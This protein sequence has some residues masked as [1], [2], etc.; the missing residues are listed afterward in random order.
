MTKLTITFAAASLLAV[1]S[2]ATV[3]AEQ[4]VTTPALGSAGQSGTMG[5]GMMNRD[6]TAG[7]DQTS[8]NAPDMMAMMGRMS[9]MMDACDA[10]MK[11]H[12]PSAGSE[13]P[14]P[15]TTPPTAK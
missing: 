6:M 14:A 4:N 5:Q 15:G 12:Q 1:A 8:A 7:H 13:A 11:N 2:A 9:R 3:H 10:M